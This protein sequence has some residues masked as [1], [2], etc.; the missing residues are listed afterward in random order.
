MIDYDLHIHNEYC[1]HAPQ[2]SV[3][4]IIERADQIGLKTIAI[5]SHIYSSQELPL[6][7]KIKTEI[8]SVKH[9]CRIIVAAE[10]DVDG[11][12]C[13]GR[14]VTDDL[15]NIECV[16]AGFHYVPGPGNYPR[17][18]EDCPL[19]PKEMFQRWK[20]SLLGLVSNPKLHILAHPGRLIGTSVDLDKFFDKSL[21]VFRQA[22][23]I[24]ADNK[25]AWEI[26]ELC[27][28]KIPENYRSRWHEIY[29]IALDEGVKLVYGSDSHDLESIGISEFTE[30]I[31]Q[32]LPSGSLSS[33]QD[34]GL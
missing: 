2:M 32:K 13:D 15:D 24:S 6:L 17:T 29:R 7:G 31:L 21:S 5:A 34:L 19:K 1:G 25:I 23:K 26:N 10:V 28:S 12:Y 30:S 14:L 16:I 27:G 11:K 33:P 9:D 4:K 22:A 3:P 18:L 8:K 20:S